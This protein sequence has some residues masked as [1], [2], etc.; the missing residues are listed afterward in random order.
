MQQPACANCS[1][2][3][4]TCEYPPPVEEGS[5][6]PPHAEWALETKPWAV[7]SQTEYHDA[8]DPSAAFG[9]H[10]SPAFLPDLVSCPTDSAAPYCSRTR[11]LLRGLIE[12]GSWFS[13]PEG[14]LWTESV[15]KAAPKYP[16]LQHCVQAI[17]HMKQHNDSGLRWPSTSAYQHQLLASRIF[18]ET[19]PRV[20]DENWL[21]VLAFAIIMLIFQFGS[22]INSDAEHFNVIETLQALRNTLQIEQAARQ[23]FRRTEFWKLVL[24]RTS[25]PDV[26]DMKLR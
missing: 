24:A 10:M 12:S 8:Y 21:P 22:Q 1:R 15:A 4:E 19:T 11:E 17:A 23:Y 7:G 5:T 14:L 18:R 16:Y 2:R 20:D 9:A 26:P 13:T 3:N 25:I 6:S